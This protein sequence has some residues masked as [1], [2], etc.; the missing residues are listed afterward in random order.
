MYQLFS[1]KK[2]EKSLGRLRQA[3]SWNEKDVRELSIIYGSIVRY[4][5]SARFKESELAFLL[6]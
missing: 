5:D 1:T 6:V 3:K 2:Y 4:S